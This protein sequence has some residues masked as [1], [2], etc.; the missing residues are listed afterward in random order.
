MYRIRILFFS[1]LNVDSPEHEV[2]LMFYLSFI[3]VYLPLLGH[4]QDIMSYN[5]TNGPSEYYAK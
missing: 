2:R 3:S 5:I 4:Y 1:V